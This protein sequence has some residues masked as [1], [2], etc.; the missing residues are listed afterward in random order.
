MEQSGTLDIKKVAVLTSGGD[1]PGMN[2]AIRSVVR[3][4]LKAGFK[5]YGIRRGYSGLISGDIFEMGTRDVSEIV[6]RGGTV[7]MTARSE[8]F[9][10][11]EGIKKAKDVLDGHGIDALI[12]IGGDGSFKGAAQLAAEGVPVIGIP[13]TIDN[14]VAATDYCIGFDTAMNTAL[15]AIDR[16][17]DT[18]SSHERC[19]VIEVMGRD[20]GNI[21]MHVGLACGA[22]VI[23]VPE[24]GYDPE[25]DVYDVIT[26]GRNIGKHHY[27]VVM[28]EG[29]GS[30]L[31][32]SQKIE[33]ATNIETRPTILGYVQRGGSPTVRDRLMAS[34]MGIKAIDCLAD[35]RTDR[36]VALAGSQITDIDIHE[37]LN[38]RKKP[39]SALVEYNQRLF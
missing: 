35:R 5:M 39:L 1:A 2:A 25:T 17:R 13:G 32:L 38:A 15:S 8:E 21:A 29:A 14:D 4:G 22:E 27:I 12:V 10:K 23:L 18:A 19:S 6:Q 26:E 3:A 16:I 24:I 9:K 37:G 28:A 30:A 31:E 33:L 36:I 7:L 11:E 34:V 20:C